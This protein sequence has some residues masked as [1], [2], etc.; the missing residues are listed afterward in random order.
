MI[1]SLVGF[2]YILKLLIQSKNI[3]RE[4]ELVRSKVNKILLS[5]TA[6]ME[7]NEPDKAI[8]ETRLSENTQLNPINADEHS[9]NAHKYLDFKNIKMNMPNLVKKKEHRKN[10]IN[11]N[12][13]EKII[14]I[15]NDRK[16]RNLTKEKAENESKKNS[17]SPKSQQKILQAPYSDP[18][19]FSF[20]N[21]SFCLENELKIE[22]ESKHTGENSSRI[23]YRNS[24]D[25][26]E[27]P[28]T[29]TP[30]SNNDNGEDV[31][32]NINT[33]RKSIE[34]NNENVSISTYKITEGEIVSER[35]KT[36]E[37]CRMASYCNMNRDSNVYFSQIG[38]QVER[39]EES[40]H[41]NSNSHNHSLQNSPLANYALQI[42]T[43]ITHQ[44]SLPQ[45]Q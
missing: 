28:Q 14:K 40:S 24:N 18:H 32:N 13:T 31:S 21:D 5:I 22:E 2:F 42:P 38:D 19:S 7:E 11:Q 6:E 12:N 16:Q 17:N 45:K 36:D 4:A 26:I 1:S 27:S 20:K 33:D 15:P 34:V 39:C 35:G 29:N 43:Q 41:A 23:L 9:K 37:D 8:T 3:K 10:E 25:K 30:N 44:N